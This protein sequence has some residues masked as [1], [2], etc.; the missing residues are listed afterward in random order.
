MLEALRKE[1]VS[2]DICFP[3]TTLAATW[4]QGVGRTGWKLED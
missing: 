3:R 1:V 2:S 4:E